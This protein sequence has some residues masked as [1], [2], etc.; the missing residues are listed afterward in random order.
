MF[1]AAEDYAVWGLEWQGERKVKF[2]TQAWV[3]GIALVD[4]GKVLLTGGYDGRLV[5]WPT[6]SDEPKPLHVVEAHEGWIRAIAVSPDGRLLASVGNDR[7]IRLWNVADG[8]AVG[9]IAGIDPGDIPIAELEKDKPK[10]EDKKDG[11]KPV[12]ESVEVAEPLGHRT[13]I[14]NVL[15][16]PNGQSLVTG[17]LMGQLIE[18]KL[19][20]RDP[21]RRWTADSLSKY[22]KGFR[23]QIGGF[24][25]M[26]F[27]A[28]GSKLFAGGITNV[29][30][31]FAGVGEPSVVEFNWA[32]NKQATE[33][34]SKPKLQGVAWGVAQHDDGTL[35]AAHGGSNGNLVFW[36]PGQADA[37]HQFKLPQNG[38]DLDLHSDGRHLAVAGSNGNL[39]IALMDK[40]AE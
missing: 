27:N 11:D 8:T 17:D 30:N 16:H 18:W 32:D 14:Y 19:E 9:E 35:I 12:D 23:A 15:F 5:W 39:W 1:F 33:Y 38:R 13:D 34:L 36:T 26:T 3:R 22:D 31:A 2:D 24:R 6:D 29:T 20:T 7:S 40:K 25:S 37:A 28:D 4:D 21:V 10:K